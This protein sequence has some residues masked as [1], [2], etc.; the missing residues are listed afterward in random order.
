ESDHPHRAP[1]F[2]KDIQDIRFAE[3]DPH[4]SPPLLV[5]IVPFEVA[6]DAAER[7]LDGDAVG[8][9]LGDDIE[10]GADY[11]DQV[12]V[13]LLTEIGFDLPAVLRD[14]HHDAHGSP[15]PIR[16]APKIPRARPRSRD[17]KRRAVS[18]FAPTRFLSRGA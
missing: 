15:T 10:R 2:V 1:P 14:R 8:G 11:S 12:A 9:P 16:V 17:L 6:V 5:P 3:I 13:V 18:D 7:D 4:R